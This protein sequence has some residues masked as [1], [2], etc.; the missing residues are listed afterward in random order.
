MSRQSKPTETTSADAGELEESPAIESLLEKVDAAPR[1]STREV[2]ASRAV[3][4]RS[5]KRPEVWQGLRAARVL[6][7]DDQGITI[8]TRRG[9]AVAQLDEGVDLTLVERALAEGDAV[10]VEQDEDG[11]VLVMGILQRKI[12]ETLELRAGKVIIEGEREVLI[13]SGKGAMRIREDGDVELVGSRIS[14]ASR[15]LFRLV[16][17]M[18]RLN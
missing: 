8:E 4:D 12:P 9:R 2:Q 18:L 3:V 6:A 11:T 15:G 7:I 14:A 13:R 17:R 10:L 5:P 1:A 16:G